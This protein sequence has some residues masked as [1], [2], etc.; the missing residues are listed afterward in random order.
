MAQGCCQQLP[1][2]PVSFKHSHFLLHGCTERWPQDFFLVIGL[3]CCTAG[4]I[5]FASFLWEQQRNNETFITIYA[6]LS[7][8]SAYALYVQL[9]QY[10]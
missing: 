1:L 5:I 9:D 3:L 7:V 2:A 4:N 10:R 8:L 6:A